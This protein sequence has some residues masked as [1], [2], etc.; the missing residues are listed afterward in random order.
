MFVV[1]LF[2]EFKEFKE[3][4]RVQGV[5]RSFKELQDKSHGHLNG[6]VLFL[7]QF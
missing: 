7:L 6:Q 2:K 4:Q 3:L 1:L 5:P